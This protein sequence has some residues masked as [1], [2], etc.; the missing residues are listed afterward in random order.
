[1]SSSIQKTTFLPQRIRPD[2]S[3]GSNFAFYGGTFD[4]VHR[5]HIAVAKAALADKRFNLKTIYFAPASIPPH[6][7]GQPITSYADRLAMVKL[8]LQETRE[9]RFVASEIESP[10]N[11]GPEA[12]QQPNYSIHSIRRLKASLSQDSD[13]DAKNPE[14]YFIVGVDSFL[15]IGSWHQPQELLKECKFIIASRPGFTFPDLASSL[16]SVLSAA[17]GQPPTAGERFFFLPTVAEDV[18]STEIREAVS[19]GEPLRN[20]VPRS[21][22][23][24]IH[25]HGLYR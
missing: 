7:Q 4:P 15:Q 17:A 5:G 23:K 10:E 16:L 14:L 20:Y 25:D 6:K 1:M 3:V 11:N 13:K 18:S 22:A 2:L 12:G 21:V 24:Y 19:H 9:R 8:A